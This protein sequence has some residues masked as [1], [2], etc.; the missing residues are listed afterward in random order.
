MASHRARNGSGGLVQRM[1]NVLVVDDHPETRAWLM[2]VV[3][4]AFAGARISP[5]PTLAQARQHVGRERF[6]LALVDLGLPDGSGCSLIEEV[7]RQSPETYL[8][9]TTIFDDDQHLFRA[10]E[11]GASGYLLKDEPEEQLVERLQGILRGNPPLA[12]G[13][14]RRILRHFHDRPRDGRQGIRHSGGKAGLLSERETE[15]LSLLAKGLNRTDVARVLDITPNTA[16]GHV[17]SI[18]R[19]LNVSGR[20]EATLEAVQM[21]IVEPPG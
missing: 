13:I 15:V 8:V 2:R 1:N 6:D 18:Y 9:V 12:P 16:A 14:A 17:K 11:A 4:A 10:L 21:G 5:A 20:A 3:R 7:S 19:K